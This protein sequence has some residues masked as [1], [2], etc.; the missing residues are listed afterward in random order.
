MLKKVRQHLAA[1]QYF[2]LKWPA[3]NR[4][5]D[6]LDYQQTNTNQTWGHQVE[7]SFRVYLLKLN[8][9]LYNVHKSKLTIKCV[10]LFTV[11]LVII[12]VCLSNLRLKW[13][14]QHCYLHRDS[15]RNPPTRKHVHVWHNTAC[16]MFRIMYTI[17]LYICMIYD[18]IVW[19]VLVYKSLDSELNPFSYF[20]YL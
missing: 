5:W 6:T 1:R 9:I 13:K 17:H 16:I 4:C 18:Y 20:P 14:M 7:K 2:D 12:I 8:V 10:I 19:P 3:F 15:I 11:Y